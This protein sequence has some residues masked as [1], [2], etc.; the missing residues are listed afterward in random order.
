MACKDK[1]VVWI[2]MRACCSGDTHLVGV[3]NQPCVGPSS[4]SGAICMCT[5]RSFAAGLVRY[6]VSDVDGTHYFLDRLLSAY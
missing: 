1:E 6:S 2:D 3:I 5:F 4:L